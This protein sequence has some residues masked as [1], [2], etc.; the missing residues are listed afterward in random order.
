V[1]DQKQFLNVKCKAIFSILLE[2][3]KNPTLQ[4]I[5]FCFKGGKSLRFCSAEN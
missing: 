5:D 3:K 4:M 2:E 1:W